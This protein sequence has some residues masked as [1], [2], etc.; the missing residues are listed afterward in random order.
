MLARILSFAEQTAVYNA[1][2]FSDTPYGSRNS[3][4]ESVGLTMLW[5]PSD[6]TISGLRFYEQC[7]GWDCT[8]V[9]ITY[10]HTELHVPGRNHAWR[11][12]GALHDQRRRGDQ[13][14][15]VLSSG[16]TESI[17][18]WMTPATAPCRL[19]PWA[20]MI[21][22]SANDGARVRLRV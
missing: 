20:R 8:T 14:R 15:S 17:R 13:L 1:I 16:T 10:N 18:C 19:L 6:G 7:A 11:L 22:Q 2:N 9:G 4:A 21:R 5:C 12:A 3:T